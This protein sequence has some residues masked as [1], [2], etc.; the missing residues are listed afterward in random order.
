MSGDAVWSTSVSLALGCQTD[1]VAIWEANL[2]V[3]AASSTDFLRSCSFV[4]GERP[5]A[6]RD[7][8]FHLLRLRQRRL[9][10]KARPPL[11]LL[12]KLMTTCLHCSRL[13]G[14]REWFGCRCMACGFE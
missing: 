11:L 8:T 9:R 6:K 3:V 5:K 13:S 2:K 10:L 4:A 14:M 1:K 12:I 7:G